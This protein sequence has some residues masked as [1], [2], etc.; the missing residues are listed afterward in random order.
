VPQVTRASLLLPVFIVGCARATLSNSDGAASE[1]RLA[2]EQR[3]AA[4]TKQDMTA[5][6]TLLDEDLTY[7]HSTGELQS[8]AA[9]IALLKSRKLVYESI[10]P[11]EVQVRAYDGIAVATGR[12]QMQVRAASGE[13]S[14]GIRFTEVYIRRGGRWLLTAWESVRLPS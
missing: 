3:F 11:S 12:S 13:M 10:A 4:M 8:K 7:V 6:D 2:E 9:F 5:L 1:V 14:F